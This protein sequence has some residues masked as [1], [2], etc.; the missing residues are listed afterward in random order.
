MTRKLLFEAVRD[1]APGRVFKPEIVPLINAVADALGLPKDT[2]P[3]GRT[4]PALVGAAPDPELVAQLKIDEGLRL[5]AYPD[6]LSVLGKACSARRLDMMDYRRVP[7]WERM[8]GAP[9]TIGYGHTGSDVH[10]GL[11]WTPAQ[12]EA[13]LIADAADHNADLALEL[14]WIARLDPVRR[15]VLQNMAF[16]LGVGS[17][18]SG[19]GLLGF[20]NTLEYV[21]TGQWAE[22]SAGMLASK[23]ARQVGDRAARLARQMKTGA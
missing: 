2:A 12:A 5:K 15:R 19:K 23:W 3:A 21:R 22:A 18:T 16:N 7:G 6:P 13:G 9:W 14:P 17:A 20:R 4:D 8:P 10:E 1:F 11:V